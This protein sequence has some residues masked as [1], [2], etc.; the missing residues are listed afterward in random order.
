MKPLGAI[1]LSPCA[2]L[3]KPQIHPAGELNLFWCE[4]E[5]ADRSGQKLPEVWQAAVPLGPP[6]FGWSVAQDGNAL[7]F[8][9]TTPHFMSS[10]GPLRWVP[11][12]LVMKND[13]CN[14]L[15][16]AQH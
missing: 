7:A 2:L 13:S 12:H 5:A 1:D 8:V 16:A 3:L 9:L 4:L 10:V 11:A 15:C 6:C 14:S